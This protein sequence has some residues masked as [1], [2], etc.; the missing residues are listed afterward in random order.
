MAPGGASSSRRSR[1]MRRAR[2]AAPTARAWLRARSGARPASTLPAADV[3]D[4]RADE[5]AAAALV[6]LRRA[7]AVLVAC[8][9]RCARRRGRRRGRSREARARRA[10]ARAAPRASS[11]AAGR[12][13]CESRIAFTATAAPTIEAIDAAGSASAASPPG[14]SASPAAA[15]RAP[16]R[17]G[18]GRAAAGSSRARREAACARTRPRARPSSRRIAQAHAVGPCTST[19]FGRAMPPSRTFSS[20]MPR[21]GSPRRRAARAAEPGRPGR[22]RR[23]ATA[24][25]SI[26]VTG[27]TSRT[28]ELRK[29]SSAA[30]SRSSAK[31]PSSH[32]VAGGRRELDEHG[33]RD[34][35]E[36]RQLERRRQ[37]P[38]ALAPPDVRGRRLEHGPAGIDE[39][40]VVGAAPLRLGLRGHVRRV[41][42]RLRAGER[43]RRPLD[44][45]EPEPARTQL[46]ERRRQR[47][48][49]ARTRPGAPPPSRPAVQ[50][51]RSDESS[52]RPT[53]RSPP[54]RRAAN[55][56]RI[57]LRQ[58]DA[59]PP[60]PASR[61]R[62]SSSR[63]GRPP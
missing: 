41:A 14:A 30:A 37:Q 46:V 16:P 56:A 36:D 10:R 48:R 26:A 17:A 25:P 9:S 18:P 55:A 24:S 49:R 53:R 22:A 39:Q 44:D 63:N 35:G 2:R 32:L 15:A 13:R 23:P 1:S 3:S 60:T 45:R 54:R 42:R 61:S 21:E 20:L 7:G 34:A 52:R 5:M 59:A 6:L 12:R 4:E 47:R 62:C 57:R 31:T 28:D 29:T 8:R 11:C 58:A 27:I 38:V 40:R 51:S 19:P 50:S 43:A 33:T